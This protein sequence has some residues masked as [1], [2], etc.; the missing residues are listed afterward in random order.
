M[1]PTGTMICPCSTGSNVGQISNEAA[2]IPV[3]KGL[4]KIPCLAGIG[5]HGKGFID[6]VTRAQ[7]VV[8]ID[9]CGVQCALKTLQHA[10]IEP[11]VHV[12]V[13]DMGI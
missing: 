9:G 7:K 2:K 1:R 3:D 10:K 12:I 11:V 6:S 13:T 5:A 8:V 4:G